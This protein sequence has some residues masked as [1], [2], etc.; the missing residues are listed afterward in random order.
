MNEG[1]L[2]LT[3]H[4]TYIKQHHCMVFRHDLNV[5]LLPLPLCKILNALRTTINILWMAF[6]I[7]YQTDQCKIKNKQITT[8][9][10][11][12]RYFI[13][14]GLF[15]T[16]K[17]NCHSVLSKPLWGICPA[18]LECPWARFRI[19]TSSREAVLQPSLTSDLPV[20]GSNRKVIFFWVQLSTKNSLG[21]CSEPSEYQISP[22]QKEEIASKGFAVCWSCSYQSGTLWM[23]WDRWNS[24]DFTY[25]RTAGCACVLCA[26]GK[27]NHFFFSNKTKIP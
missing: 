15:H 27:S 25:T 19:P 6:F 23:R 10:D 22:T 8:Y 20:G 14:Q 13:L 24:I 16:E 9:L 4:M 12:V 26:N 21:K 2:F 18:M 7:I 1:L 5:R 3:N 17:F 11:G